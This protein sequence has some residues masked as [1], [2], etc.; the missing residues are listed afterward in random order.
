MTMDEE[1]YTLL[2]ERSSNS[3]N[4][5]TLVLESN[6]GKEKVEINVAR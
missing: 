4:I 2:K 1:V 6:F 3:E 5:I